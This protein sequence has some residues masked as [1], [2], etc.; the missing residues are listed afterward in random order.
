MWY[1]LLEDREGGSLRGEGLEGRV[2]QGQSS[3][4]PCRSSVTLALIRLVG[5]LL[6]GACWEGR[7][8]MFMK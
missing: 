1:E 5:F 3:S 2:W 8:V 6:V 4:G 7:K